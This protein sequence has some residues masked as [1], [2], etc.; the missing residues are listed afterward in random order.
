MRCLGLLLILTIVAAS[1]ADIVYLRGGSC[2]YGEVIRKDGQILVFREVLPSGSGSAVRH[3]RM[4]D[5]ARL[6]HNGRRQSPPTPDEP[7]QQPD[8][9]PID[10]D[11]VFRE[12][13]ELLRDDDQP[14]ALRALQMIPLEAPAA[15][16]QHVEDC[17]E[18]TLGQPLPELI[19]RLRV[20]V[21]GSVGDGLGFR[22]TN[23]TR[24]ER[25]ALGRILKEQIDDLLGRVHLD[26]TVAEWAADR[27]AYAELH[28]GARYMVID[29]TRAAALISA[30]LRFD[31]ALA[32][33]RDTR[34]EL[35]KLRAAL[36][37][38][39]ARVR[40]QTGFTSLPRPDDWVDPAVGF[41]QDIHAT[42]QPARVG[43]RA[44]N[45]GKRDFQDDFAQPRN[46]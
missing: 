13:V 46:P 29:V 34:I 26:R 39:S 36:A 33:D 25:A 41:L 2:H 27:D 43:A 21:A 32:D 30:R 35:S 7:D 4:S 24:Y 11:Q 40:M 44:E 15:A 19:A 20:R 38:L 3:F 42:T 5:V 8:E 23:A 17:C 9:S 37:Q 6:D 45:S 14:A 10:F 12:A 28:P 1:E 31:E 18:S 22:L 16:L